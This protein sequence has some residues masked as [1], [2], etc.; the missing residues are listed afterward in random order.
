MIRCSSF[1]DGKPIF[2]FLMSR[3]LKPFHTF[4]CRIHL[5]NG[6]SEPLGRSFSTMYR[7]GALAIWIENYVRLKNITTAIVRIADF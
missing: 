4:R 7:F 2:E 1:T 6:S 5:S 3:K